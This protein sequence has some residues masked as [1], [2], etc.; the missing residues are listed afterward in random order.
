MAALA[1]ESSPKNS[2]IKAK[3][4][5]PGAKEGINNLALLPLSEFPSIPINFRSKGVIAKSITLKPKANIGKR[6]KLPSIFTFNKAIKIV[7]GKASDRIIFFN[8]FVS[9]P[10][11]IFFFKIIPIIIKSINEIDFSNAPSIN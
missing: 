9:S 6:I 2:N 3:Q 5:K 10:V 1:K 7:A 11:E 4:D 8:P